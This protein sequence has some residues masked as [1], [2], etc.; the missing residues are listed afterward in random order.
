MTLSY[1]LGSVS[2]VTIHTTRICITIC[3]RV[4]IDNKLT[5]DNHIKR[6]CK[7]AGQNSSSLSRILAFIDLNKGQVLFQSMI[8]LNRN[9]VTAL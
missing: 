8:K 4:T 9:L 5:F 2:P 6:I 3:N 1:F 7:K